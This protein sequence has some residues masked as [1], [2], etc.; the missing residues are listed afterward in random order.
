VGDTGNNQVAHLSADGTELWRGGY[1]RSVSVNPSDGSC[2]VPGVVSLPCKPPI[3]GQVVHLSADGAELWL[4]GSFCDPYAVSVNPAD[5]SCWVADRFGGRI[6]HLSPDGSE[7]SEG[8]GRCPAS[9][10]VNPSDGSCWAADSGLMPF[11]YQ[12]GSDV[13]HL[14]ADGADLWRQADFYYPGSVS[15]NPTDGSCWVADTGNSQVVHLVIARPTAEFT[16]SP[17]AGPVPLEVDFVDLSVSSPT[18]PILAWDWDFGD[19][20]VSTE[21]N[22]THEYT[23]VGTYTVSLTVSDATRSDTKTKKRYIHVTFPDVPV[24][25]WAM[26]EI[27]ACVDAGVVQGYPDGTYR[28]NQA[29]TRDQ[30]AVYISRALAGGDANVPTGPA[31]ATFPDVPTD[32]WAFKYVQYCYDQAVVEGYWDG[33]HPS[34][35]VTRAQ[36]AVY[37]ARSMVAPSGDAAI[38]EPPGPPTFPDVPDTYW[39]YKWIEYCHAQGIVQGYWDGYHPEEV[40][41]RAQMAVYVQRAFALPM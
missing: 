34:E 4:G 17:L 32:H 29:V 8:G 13:A 27:L 35:V 6:V 23:K 19:G 28:P 36:M 38:P 37:I 2:W 22:P 3:H 33:Y 5:G 7:L 30:M 39:A 14:S 31:T 21:Q 11:P 20:A 41:N 24:D 15:V 26:D 1:G 10:S 18:A 16:A 25:Y 9:V 40:V 12:P